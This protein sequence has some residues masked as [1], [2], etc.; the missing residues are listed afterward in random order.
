M[1]T[2]EKGARKADPDADVVVASVPTL[3]RGSQKK[4]IVHMPRKA[5]DEALVERFRGNEDY[6]RACAIMGYEA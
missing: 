6:L 3:G 2:Q 4:E 5:V 1:V